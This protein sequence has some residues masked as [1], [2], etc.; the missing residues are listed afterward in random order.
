MET[1][2]RFFTKNGA[3]DAASNDLQNGAV[4]TK[5]LNVVSTAQM[6]LYFAILSKLGLMYKLSYALRVRCALTCHNSSNPDSHNLTCVSDSRSACCIN[7]SH[8]AY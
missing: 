2:H 1:T 3:T 5:I 7:D 8:I 6:I 4:C